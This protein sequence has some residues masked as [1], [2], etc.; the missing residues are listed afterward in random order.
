VDAHGH[1]MYK[2]SKYFIAAVALL[3]VSSLLLIMWAYWEPSNIRKDT[4][5]YRLMIPTEV[6][7]FPAWGET[8]KPEYSVS[9][10][11]GLKP[12][13]VTLRYRSTLQPAELSTEAT[14]LNFTCQQYPTGGTVCEKKI[15]AGQTIQVIL[16]KAASDTNSKVEVVF[17]GY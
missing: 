3:L 8:D 5:V 4:L 16:D 17:S 1:T 13:A 11:A 10:A 2:L 6:K 14:K 9:I 15:N 12:C 7:A